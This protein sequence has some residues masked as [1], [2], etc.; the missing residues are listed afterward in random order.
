MKIL[1]DIFIGSA[2]GVILAFCQYLQFAKIIH[3][4]DL[5]IYPIVFVGTYFLIF[6][7]PRNN[8]YVPRFFSSL[9]RSLWIWMSCGLVEG[10]ILYVYVS[11]A[12][13]I[14]KTPAQPGE[15]VADG[16]A[17]TLLD[18]LD[19]DP[20]THFVLSII[21]SFLLGILLSVVG[22]I[23]SRIINKPKSASAA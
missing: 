1:R 16:I 6:Y 14:F 18:S 13:P 9:G 22:F 10:C 23:I 2:L 3:S 19:Q 4:I 5:F 11:L 15:T 7:F 12:K 17:R 20:W 21:A 8:Q